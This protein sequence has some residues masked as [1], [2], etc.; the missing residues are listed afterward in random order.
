MC[1]FESVIIQ[2]IDVSSSKV[3][4]P[5]AAAGIVKTL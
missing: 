3:I 5:K 2:N 4:S 1:L